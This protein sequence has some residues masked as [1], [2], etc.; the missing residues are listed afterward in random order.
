MFKTV[1]TDIAERLSSLESSI[2]D[3]RRLLWNASQIGDAGAVFRAD[4]ILENLIA[5]RDG[6]TALRRRAYLAE[7]V[8]G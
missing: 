3:A 2:L 5:E 8:D 4:R 1:P 7:E 6:L